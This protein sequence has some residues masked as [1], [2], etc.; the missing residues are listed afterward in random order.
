MLGE[1]PQARVLVDVVLSCGNLELMGFIDVAPEKRHLKQV[2]ERYPV[3]ELEHL[4]DLLKSAPGEVAVI[5][6][7]AIPEWRRRLI[8]LAGQRRLP[9][10]RLVYPGTVVGEDA[11][12]GEGIIVMPGVIIGPGAWLGDHVTINCAATVDHDTIIGDNVTL[13]LGVHLAGGVVVER[14]TFIGIG[15]VCPPGVTIGVNCI[16]GDG[17]VVI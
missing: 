15:A 16:I 5:I 6:A 8:E 13:S 7:T 2:G 12:I 9:L 11:T 10:A 3:W 4:D 1:G 17:S 14:D